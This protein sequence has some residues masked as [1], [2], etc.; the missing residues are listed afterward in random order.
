M[1]VDFFYIVYLEFRN[2]SWTG[3]GRL[4]V[5]VERIVLLFSPARTDG[6]W[7]REQSSFSYAR[8]SHILKMWPI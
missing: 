2:A 8:Y 5:A 6:V 4:G 3:A 1:H 7:R